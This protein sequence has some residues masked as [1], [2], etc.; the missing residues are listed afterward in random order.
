MEVVVQVPTAAVNFNF[1]SA[2]SS[3]YMTAPSSPQRFGSSFFFSAPTSP[4]RVSASVPFQWEEKPG[5][6]KT[7]GFHGKL[8]KEDDEDFEFEFSGQL[9]RTSLSADELFQGGKVR[10]LN[11]FDPFETPIHKSRKGSVPV[12]PKQR[13]RDRSSAC[14]SSSSSSYYYVHKKSRSLSPFKAS[15]DTTFEQEITS[16]PKSYVSSILSAISFSKGNWKWKLKDLLLLR[17]AS[18]GRA[19]GDESFRNFAVSYN[20]DAEDINNLS[21]RSTESVGSSSRR[22]GRVS[23]HELHYTANRAISEEM[24]RKTFLPYRQ[25]L[26]GCLGFNPP[27]HDFS[28]SI[29]SFRRR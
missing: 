16:N 19:T 26:L 20:K 1:D 3:P 28:R 24:R 2:C 25:G 22:R 9:E 7:K 18:E 6:P 12:E 21:F 27:I 14:S 4:T 15:D 17:S 23:A 8:D 13:G 10:P 29:V 5:I 11:H